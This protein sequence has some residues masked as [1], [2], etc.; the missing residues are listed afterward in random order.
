MRYSGGD[1]PPPPTKQPALVETI[2]HLSSKSNERRASSPARLIHFFRSVF[3]IHKTKKKKGSDHQP[4]GFNLI[5][6]KQKTKK[7]RKKM[8]FLIYFG[9]AMCL[10]IIRCT[11]IFVANAANN[12]IHIYIYM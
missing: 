12:R 1:P 4:D 9:C 6:K 7:E 3:S 10:C 5:M 8:K 11:C 2:T